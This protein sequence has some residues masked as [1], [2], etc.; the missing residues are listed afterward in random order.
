M[1]DP[2]LPDKVI[3]LAPGIVQADGRFADYQ[4]GMYVGGHLRMEAAVKLAQ[5]HPSAEFIL[6]GGYNKTGEGDP[7][8]S[9][10]VNDMA[11]YMKEHVPTVK[12]TPIY[13]LPC[14]RHNFV[15]V[16]NY[17]RAHGTKNKTVGVLTNSYHM[18]R[19][20]EFAQQAM[21]L[22]SPKNPAS[23]V[24]VGAEE[25]LGLSRDK[26]LLADKK[27]AQRL[28]SEKRGLEALKNGSY[29]DSCL[30]L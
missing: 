16:L 24:P 21:I 30:A 13:S 28:E 2:T 14:T 12:L 27:Y 29:I 20:L 19:A 10:K 15:A 8:T 1:S 9:D 25:I 17:W 3:V 11:R 18:E 22:S 6:V 23:F 5:T 26:S 7:H 4:G